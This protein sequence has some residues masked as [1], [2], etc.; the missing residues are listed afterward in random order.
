[1]VGPVAQWIRHLTTDQGIPGSA[2]SFNIYFSVLFQIF[3]RCIARSQWIIPSRVIAVRVFTDVF[4]CFQVTNLRFLDPVE[5][6]DSRYM[7]GGTD[8]ALGPNPRVNAGR[9]RGGCIGG[10][11]FYKN[12]QNNSP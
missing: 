10:R 7:S 6:H 3:S 4:Y 8:P 1:M 9:G 12:S 11:A 5:Y 2:G